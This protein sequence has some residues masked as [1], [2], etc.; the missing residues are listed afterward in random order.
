MITTTQIVKTLMATLDDILTDKTPSGSIVPQFM[1]TGSMKGAYV[2]E[3]E[4]GG[5]GLLQE[6]VEGANAAVGTITEGGTVRY[7]A[8]TMA[9]HLHISEEA[10]EDCKYSKVIAAAKMLAGSAISTQDYDGANMIIRSTTAT[11]RGGTDDVCLGSASHTIPGGA[12]ASNL[13]SSA[14]T[15]MTPSAAALIAVRTMAGKFPGRNGLLQGQVP[16]KIDGIELHVVKMLPATWAVAVG[17]FQRPFV[18]MSIHPHIRQCELLM[19]FRASLL[20]HCAA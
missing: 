3:A 4:Y 18:P 2:E 6:K 10:I 11:A 7:L 15:Y 12:T 8:R 17:W 13:L 20:E 19:T 5:T 16:R 1:K 9:L 14:G